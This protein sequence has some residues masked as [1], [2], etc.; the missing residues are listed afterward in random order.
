M[1][2]PLAPTIAR[3]DVYL[4]HL[5]PTLGSEIRKTRPCVVVSPDEMNHHLRTLIVAPMTTQG[6]A[7]PSRVA[8][9][10]GGTPGQVVL[11]QIRTVD[12][13]RLGRRLGGLD[14]TTGQRILEILAALFAA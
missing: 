5:D 11:D 8:V 14:Q 2:E 7:Y 4:V 9:T 10:F 3:F 1:A 12:R 6:R 13:T